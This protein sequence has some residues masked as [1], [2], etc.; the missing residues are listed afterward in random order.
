MEVLLEAN[1]DKPTPIPL[2]TNT[3]LQ[4]LSQRQP[5]DSW[6][7]RKN[8][9]PTLA[10]FCD[11]EPPIELEDDDRPVARAIKLIMSLSLC[12]LKLQC[13]A[14]GKDVELITMHRLVQE[15][16]RLNRTDEEKYTW[17][18]RFFN[19]FSSGSVRDWSLKSYEN[20]MRR[21]AVLGTVFSYL[22]QNPEI[23]EKYMGLIYDIWED[24]KPGYGTNIG[25]ECLK[26]AVGLVQAV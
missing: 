1:S 19:K 24:C 5:R 25:R 8:L 11:R 18:V 12:G 4:W 16:V 15:I 9:N 20:F 3:Q 26:V 17:L 14:S 21:E 7:L 23:V 6:C 10:I 13:N 2:A 22:H